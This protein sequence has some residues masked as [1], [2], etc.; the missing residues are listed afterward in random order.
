[1]SYLYLKLG[2]WENEIVGDAL[3]GRPEGLPFKPTGKGMIETGKR[4]NGETEKRGNRETEK[5]GNGE[6]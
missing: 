1:L 2:K 6:K 4:V 3:R 5:R